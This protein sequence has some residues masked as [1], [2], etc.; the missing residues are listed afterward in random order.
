ML[1]FICK[2]PGQSL[3]SLRDVGIAVAAFLVD[4]VVAV[5]VS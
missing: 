5:V 2:S 3:A 1:K 4:Y